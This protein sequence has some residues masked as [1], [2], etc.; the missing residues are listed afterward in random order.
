MPIHAVPDMMPGPPQHHHHNQCSDYHTVTESGRDY[1]SLCSQLHILNDQ[2][3][4]VYMFTYELVRYTSTSSRLLQASEERS[5][6]L[7]ESGM[8]S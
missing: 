7:S 4:C 5:G 8:F 6:L 2:L 3:R 1:I